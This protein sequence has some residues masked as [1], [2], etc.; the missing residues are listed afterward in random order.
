MF[1]QACTIWT[2]PAQ[3]SKWLVIFRSLRCFLVVYLG[4]VIVRD[5]FRKLLFKLW[6]ILIMDEVISFI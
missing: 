6:I 5:Y 3:R 1:K 2:M 4:E